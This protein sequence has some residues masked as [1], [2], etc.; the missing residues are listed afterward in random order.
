MSKRRLL[1]ASIQNSC[2]KTGKK[3]KP[4]SLM[5]FFIYFVNVYFENQ[6]QIL[7]SN[8]MMCNNLI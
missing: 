7:G 4:L 2:K 1:L 6:H 8:L 3:D 5:T